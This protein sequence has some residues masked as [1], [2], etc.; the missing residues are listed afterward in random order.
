[1]RVWFSAF[2]PKFLEIFQLFLQLVKNNWLRLSR[3]V[4][5]C[6]KKKKLEGKKFH[7]DAN[8]VGWMQFVRRNVVEVDYTRLRVPPLHQSNQIFY[9]N[10]ENLL[11]IFGNSSKNVSL[12][13]KL[14][15]RPY[16]FNKHLTISITINSVI[17]NDTSRTE[18]FFI[19]LIFF[20]R[21]VRYLR[22]NLLCENKTRHKTLIQ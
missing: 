18:R 16:Y 22:S 7:L 20:H 13:I 17:I 19:L 10:K 11:N 3:V 4:K 2:P 15:L 9:P 21:S 5:R 1:M 8:R 6:H 12:L 14:R